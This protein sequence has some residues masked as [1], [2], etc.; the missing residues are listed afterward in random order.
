MM[1]ITKKSQCRVAGEF[2]FLSGR[3]GLDDNNSVVPG[4]IA[5]Q[6]RLALDH[7]EDTLR[8]RGLDR[9]HIIK[10]NVFLS[11]KEHFPEFNRVYSEFF[12]GHELPARR[13]IVAELVMDDC[14]IEIDA[15]AC[16]NSATE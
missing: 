14:L 13:T 4:G 11:G 6:T 7:L 3:A 8:E 15:V 12:A 5:A 9:S 1:D 16:R 10:A 2:V